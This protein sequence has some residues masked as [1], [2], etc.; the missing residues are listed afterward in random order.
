MQWA[1]TAS[2]DLLEHDVASLERDRILICL[3]IRAE[4]AERAVVERMRRL[5]RDERYTEVA[6]RRLNEREVAVWLDHVFAHQEID[7]AIVPLL[8]RYSEGNRFLTTQILR[9][10]LDD[11]LVQFNGGRWELRSRGDIQLPA[12]VAGLMERRLERLSPDPRRMLATAAVI[13][14]VFDIDLACS[15]GAGTE[16]ELLDAV[17]EGVAHAVLEP[18]GTGGSSYSFT[19]SLLVNAVTTSINARRL[20][21]IHERVAVALEAHAPTPLAVH[22]VHYERLGNSETTSALEF[23]ST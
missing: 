16:D 12:A 6:L 17:D 1:D 10:L 14:R 18:V 7:P 8:Q 2:W 20:S 5:S 19:H 21:R 13:G 22:P 23:A 3:T 9:T 4:D 15:S 11:K